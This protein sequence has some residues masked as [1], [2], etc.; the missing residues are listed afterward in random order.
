MLKVSRFVAVALL[1]TGCGASLSAVSRSDLPLTGSG[2]SIEL[3]AI[4]GSPPRPWLWGYVGLMQAKQDLFMKDHPTP[5]ELVDSG[6][7]NE[8]ERRNVSVGEGGAIKLSCNLDRFE[9]RVRDYGG[10]PLAADYYA[11]IDLDC[12][13]V[14]RQGEPL[15]SGKVKGRWHEHNARDHWIEWTFG[16][17]IEQIAAQI[18][19]HVDHRPVD[20]AK[21][22]A[23]QA[24]VRAN[25][26][27][28]RRIGA[29]T[30]GLSRDPRQIPL[31]LS[32]LDDPSPLVRS[33]AC[34]SLGLI[35]TPEALR[36]MFDRFE[37]ELH[38]GQGAVRWGMVAA[39]DL[40]GDAEAKSWLRTVRPALKRSDA[41][42]LADEILA[43]G[44]TAHD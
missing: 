3:A 16:A 17:A 13:A 1:S 14:S 39:V 31:L 44:P 2:P 43:Q 7:R 19:S 18:L 23:A 21:M 36:P 5:V 24:L 12:R 32:L 34:V 33:A 41:S 37:N 6:L 30:I 22:T 20:T 42:I 26:E 10:W 40:A 15:W 38:S 27:Q 29:L 4:T 9:G 11:L 25:V 28:A 8:L 35:G